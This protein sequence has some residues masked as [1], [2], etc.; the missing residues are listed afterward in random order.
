MVLKI[1][2]FKNPILLENLINQKSTSYGKKST[3]DPQKKNPSPL[4]KRAP[5]D[6]SDKL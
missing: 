5:A 3:S 2:Q 6:P 1:T 4:S